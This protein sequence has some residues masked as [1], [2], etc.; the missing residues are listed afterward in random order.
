MQSAL[1]SSAFHNRRKPVEIKNINNAK[2][3]TSASKYNFH[4]AHTKS[5]LWDYFG[6]RSLHIR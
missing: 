2:V 6:I 3:I 5:N 4:A 1:F